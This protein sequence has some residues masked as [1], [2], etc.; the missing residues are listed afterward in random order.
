MG[1]GKDPG[2]PKFQ[3]RVRDEFTGEVSAEMLT[4]DQICEGLEGKDMNLEDIG[5]ALLNDLRAGKGLESVIPIEN[6]RCFHQKKH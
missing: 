3:I 1:M 4:K 6:E 2:I 5:L